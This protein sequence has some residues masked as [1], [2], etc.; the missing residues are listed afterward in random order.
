MNVLSNL[1]PNKALANAFDDSHENIGGGGGKNLRKMD[2]G[3]MRDAFRVRKGAP[4]IQKRFIPDRDA[5]RPYWPPPLY[6]NPYGVAHAKQY[7]ESFYDA[8]AYEQVRNKF[9]KFF[10]EIVFCSVGKLSRT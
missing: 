6:D 10:Q 3:M 8:N 5:E 7:Y 9:V 2:S 1:N 4:E